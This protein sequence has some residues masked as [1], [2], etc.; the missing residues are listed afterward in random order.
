[1]SIIKLLLKAWAKYNNHTLEWIEEGEII[2]Y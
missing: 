1:M 2:G